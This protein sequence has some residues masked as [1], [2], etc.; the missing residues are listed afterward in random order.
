MADTA[1]DGFRHGGSVMPG[2]HSR[3]FKQWMWNG[4]GADET[5]T[6]PKSHTRKCTGHAVDT[7]VATL[8][9]ALMSTAG[10]KTITDRSNHGISE[11]RGF[12]RFWQVT[13]RIPSNCSN[14]THP[15]HR[16]HRGVLF[17]HLFQHYSVAY[18]L[19]RD[20]VLYYGTAKSL[21]YV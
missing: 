11:G 1:S 10:C 9:G 15:A 17:L 2:P 13:L 5:L 6:W 16:P 20:I 21:G 18:T 3:T 19:T 4:G 14:Q 7:R 12:L 8:Y